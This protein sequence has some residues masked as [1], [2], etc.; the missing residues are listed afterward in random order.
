MKSRGKSVSAL[1]V[2]DL[3]KCPVWA[4]TNNDKQGELVVQAVKR[5]P[6]AS[7]NGKL[8]GLQVKLANG[9][10]LWALL[11]NLDAKNAGLTEHFLTLSIKV[12]SEWF[13][14]ARYHDHDYEQRGPKALSRLL[15]LPIDDIFPIS[16]DVRQFVQEAPAHLA[17]KI[18]KEPRKRLTRE[19]IIALAVP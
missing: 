8:F 15:T 11:G 6:V 18:L 5:L 10:L 4:Y 12:H 16:Y 13:N 9:R 1:Q 14:L 17:G 7:L 19:E 2:S 3:K